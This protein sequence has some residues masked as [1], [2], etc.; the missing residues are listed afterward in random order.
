MQNVD[1]GVCSLA[2]CVDVPDDEIYLIK[3]ENGIHGTYSQVFYSPR[4][5]RHRVYTVCGTLGAMEIDLGEYDG[6]ILFTK[7]YSSNYDKEV[8]E[9]DYVKRNH[10]NGDGYMCRHFYEVITKNVEPLATVEQAF[11][12]EALGYASILSQREDRQVAVAEIIPDDLKDI[13]EKHI[14]FK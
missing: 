12:A 11:M 1:L 9:F 3:F 5:F 2:K 14:D 7:R 4:S 10:Y 8:L 6:K 13:L